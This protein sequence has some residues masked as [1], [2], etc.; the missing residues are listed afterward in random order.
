MVTAVSLHDKKILIVEDQYLIAADLGRVLARLGGVIVGPVAST[1]AAQAEIAEKDVD[2][3]FLDI[4]LNEQMVFPLAD[5]LDRRGIPFIFATG[6][7]AAVVP[8][9]FKAKL[10]LEKPFTAHSVQEAVRQL[11]L[12]R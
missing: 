2:L 1:E 9:R 6:H 5:E 11:S 8:D 10:R 7:D 12:S 4:N 3:A